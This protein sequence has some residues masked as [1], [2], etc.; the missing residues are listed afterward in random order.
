MGRRN[1]WLCQGIEKGFERRVNEH[2]CHTC[3]VSSLAEAIYCPSYD[4]ATVRTHLV[5]PVYVVILFPEA[6]SHI[7]T[8]LSSPPEA[9]YLLS[10]DQ[11]NDFTELL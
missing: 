4:Q 9:I 11:A 1:D 6:A 5:C 8:V 7:C 3:T 2:G 10:G